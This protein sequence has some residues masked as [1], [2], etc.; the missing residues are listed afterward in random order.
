[1]DKKDPFELHDK[2]DLRGLTMIILLT[3]F[4][5]CL[6]FV[7][8]KVEFDP[9]KMIDGAALAMMLISLLL[10]TLIGGFS[11][12]G[13]KQGSTQNQTPQLQVPEGFIAEFKN[14]IWVISKDSS[15]SNAGTINPSSTR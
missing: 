8:W 6:G 10:G 3:V 13:L 15:G 14:G 7:L 5:V 9:A 12:M 4:V 1:M 11:W 2:K